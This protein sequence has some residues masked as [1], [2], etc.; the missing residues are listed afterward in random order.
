MVSALLEQQDPYRKLPFTNVHYADVPEWVRSIRTRE[1][2]NHH[3]HLH[4]VYIGW[5]YR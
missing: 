4:F 1:H 5:V 2:F 3:P